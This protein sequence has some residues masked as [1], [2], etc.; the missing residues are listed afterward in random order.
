M[1][2]APFLQLELI[3]GDQYPDR[4]TAQEAALPLIAESLHAVIRDL[5]ARG[6]LVEIDGKII[7]NPTT[8]P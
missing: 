1:K 4:D 8:K 3:S 6:V 2:T 7:P 5:L